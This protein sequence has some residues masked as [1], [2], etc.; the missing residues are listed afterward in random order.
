MTDVTK[1]PATVQ[2]GGRPISDLAKLLAD[3]ALTARFPLHWR[4]MFTTPT[5]NSADDTPDVPL[6]AEEKK[7]LRFEGCT[8]LA[9][10]TTVGNLPFRRVCIDYG[11][12]ITIGEMAL[13]QEFLTGNKNEWSLVRRHP[14]EKM[15]GLQL[16]GNRPQTLVAATEHLRKESPDVDFIDVNLGCPI[17]LVVK[18]GGGSALLDQATKLGKILKG[19]SFASGNIPVTIKMRTGIKTG[20]NT[21]HRLMPKVIQE[22][23]VG[24][25]TVSRVILFLL[26]LREACLL[27]LCS[28]VVL[29]SRPNPAAE[30]HQAR[31]LRLHQDLRGWTP[32]RGR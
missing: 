23:G 6:R 29:D 24:A 11:V 19:M 5:T 32:C 22:W 26:V 12:D 17:D 31:R 20:V 13:A 7:R 14:S 4:P 18:K 25:L 1:S 9:P 10:L 28:W 21:T 30:V 8:Y 3:A 15:F 16:C 27:M 2:V